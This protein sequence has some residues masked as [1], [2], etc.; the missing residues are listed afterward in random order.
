M[1]G[2]IPFEKLYCTF[3]YNDRRDVDFI[4]PFT[5]EEFTHLSRYIETE[6]KNYSDIVEN[7]EIFV[8]K[9]DAVEEIYG[10]KFQPSDTIRFEWFDG[11]EYHEDTFSIGGEITNEKHTAIQSV[12]PR[13]ACPDGF[14]AG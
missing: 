12:L 8:L 4:V 7:R 1:K 10:W 6:D 9:N 3:E 5:E 13:S 2:I 11:T 14:N